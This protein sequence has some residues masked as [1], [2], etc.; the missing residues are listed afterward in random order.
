MSTLPPRS[1]SL[2]PFFSPQGVA[3]IGASRDPNK[4]SYGVVRNLVDPEHGY[5]GPVYP[6]NP[7]AAEILGRRCRTCRT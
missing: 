3:I 4:L 1:A 7:K 6:V 5:P 2:A